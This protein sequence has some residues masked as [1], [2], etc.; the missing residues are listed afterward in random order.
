MLQRQVQVLIQLVVQH[1]GLV[2]IHLLLTTTKTNTIYNEVVDVSDTSYEA[3]SK[4]VIP[5]A[6]TEQLKVTFTAT[7]TGA[8]L[9]KMLI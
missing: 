3:Q 7:I 5:Q 8:G 9:N 2:I 4:L 1:G 6:T